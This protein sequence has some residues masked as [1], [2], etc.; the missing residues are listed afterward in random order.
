MK[1]QTN[2]CHGDKGGTRTP[3]V[4]VATELSE[5]LSKR[6]AGYALAA[7]AAGV[8]LLGTAA[9]G[10]A[11]IVYTSANVG[12]SNNSM[13]PIDLNHDGIADFTISDR[14]LLSTLPPQGNGAGNNYFWTGHLSL[15]LNDHNSAVD[16][17]ASSFRG[18]GVARLQAGAQIPP[19]G[20]SFSFG[21]VG[22][23]ASGTA[24][25]TSTGGSA[26]RYRGPWGR[27]VRN[28]A[29]SGFIGLKFFING[30]AHYGWA[31]LGN[32]Q[33]NYDAEYGAH[34]S[35]DGGYS[36][37]LVSY[38]Y[39][40]CANVGI[41]AGATSGGGTCA[42]PEPGTLGLLALGSLGLGFWRRKKQESVRSDK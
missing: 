40:S 41:I 18:V 31:Y 6:L 11:D 25:N 27:S 4:R 3:K 5:S 35:G 29:A 39:E 19:T 21:K 34:G 26:S 23:M 42:T 1:T 20:K 9:L 10:K 36:G 15:G 2:E 37:T 12:F 13:T 24:E 38:A 28:F 33:T 22:L 7:G 30:Q 17:P 8:G 16:G 32:V 14:G